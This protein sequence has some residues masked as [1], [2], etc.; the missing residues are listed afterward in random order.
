MK[1]ALL[2]FCCCLHVGNLIAE[3][4]SSRLL[5]SSVAP[6][7]RD[8]CIDCH[9]AETTTSLDLGELSYDLADPAAFR[10]WVEVYDQLANGDMP[11]DSEPRPDA[12]QLRSAL[13]CLRDSLRSANLDDRREHGRVPARRL[14]RLEYGYTVGDLLSIESDFASV[15]PSEPNDGMF[16]TVGASQRISALH[17]EAYLTAAD[18][19]IDSAI[20]LS[21]NPHRSFDFDLLNNEHLNSFHEK[22]LRLGG[23]ISRKLDDGVVLFRDVDYLLRSDL[24][25][26]KVRHAGYYRINV[27]AEA[28]QSQDPVAFK[29][30]VKDRSGQTELVGAGDLV[31]GETHTFETKAYLTRTK[32]FYVAM[33]EERP[34][35]EIL[36]DILK[37]GSAK[38]YQGKGIAI[39]SLHVEGPLAEQWPPKS[40][41]QLLGSAKLINEPDD[42]GFDVELSKPMASHVEEV[43]ARI[44]PTAYRRPLRPGELD[45][46]IELTKPAISEGRSLADVVRIPLR[47]ILTS[48]QFLLFTGEPNKLDDYALASRLSYFLW[49]RMPDEELFRLAE[50]GELVQPDVLSQQVERMLNDD[51]SVRFIRDFLGQW[52]RLDE[53]DDSTPD[54]KLYPEYDDLLHWSI[55]R[56]TVAFFKELVDENLSVANLIDSDFIF[57]SRRLAQHYGI[58]GVV[59]QHLQKIELPEGSC[60]GGLLTQASVLKITA[61]G[62]TTSPVTRGDFVLRSLLGTPAP[63]PPEDVA[64]IEPDTSGAT[65]IRETLDRHSNVTD[66]AVCHREIDPPGFALESFDPI[67]GFRTHYRARIDRAFAYVQYKEG[68]QVDSSGITKE[69]VQFSGVGDFKKYLLTKQEQVAK[70]LISQLIVYSTGGEIQFADRDELKTIAERTRE[71]RFPLRTI[72]HEVVQSSIFRNR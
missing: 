32:V 27:T 71:K 31:P 26:F 6:L 23:N 1:R 68:P 46:L 17:M 10:Q 24:H 39:K 30:V 41:H 58:D 63:P 50:Q 45:A 44:A 15:I 19:A 16:D 3:E 29:V 47:A 48:P 62:T 61:N 34:H 20:K 18:Q 70:N 35:H 25:G 37:S 66:C 11:P 65:T 7:I 2:A 9:D 56:E 28:F 72:I 55:P 38:Q 40:T 14:T 36:L 49:K 5:R 22:E 21:A 12:E 60:R 52:L 13:A 53:L 57:V 33:V 69:G 51:R 67:G 64:A 8:S 42:G 4:S 54:E 43:V 59:G